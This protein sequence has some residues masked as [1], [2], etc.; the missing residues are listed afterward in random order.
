MELQHELTIRIRRCQASAN[1]DRVN[2]MD[3]TI[4][5]RY[6]RCFPQ[7]QSGE[8]P[9]HYWSPSLGKSTSWNLFCRKTKTRSKTLRLAMEN[10]IIVEI[11]GDLCTNVHVDVTTRNRMRRLLSPKGLDDRIL[12]QIFSVALRIVRS[13]YWC[14]CYTLASLKVPITTLRINFQRTF[15]Q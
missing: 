2:T 14:K 7:R 3:D 10:I 1:V 4:S 12:T 13:K 6:W 8:W 11:Y 5:R 9:Q 15:P